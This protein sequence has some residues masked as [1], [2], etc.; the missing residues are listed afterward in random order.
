MAQPEIRRI[1]ERVSPEEVLR[2][3]VRFKQV[4]PNWEAYPEA[5]LPAFQRALYRYIGSAAGVDQRVP[6]A[7]ATGDVSVALAYADP[8]RGAPLHDHTAQEIFFALTG[9][10]RIYF[11]DEGQEQVILEP[12]DAVLVPQG[13]QRGFAN[14][15]NQ[16]GYLM[17]IITRGDEPFPDYSSSVLEALERA[18]RPG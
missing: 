15:G 16:P 11:G 3:V 10:W 1:P 18:T 8:G 2:N 9:S 17:A 14:A 6:P 12:W 4:V 5:A 7:V 13:I